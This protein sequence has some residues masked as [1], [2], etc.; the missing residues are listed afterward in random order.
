M[1]ESQVGELSYLR[2]AIMVSKKE[3]L[4]VEFSDGY[5]MYREEGSGVKDA[6]WKALYDWDMLGVIAASE[7]GSVAL[8]LEMGN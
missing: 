4:F 5:R 3:R 6:T 8:G 1:S 7:D 2:R